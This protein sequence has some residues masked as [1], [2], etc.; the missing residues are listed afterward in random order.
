MFRVV[1]DQL[2][3]SEGW[4]RC[5][6][7]SEVFDATAFLTDESASELLRGEESAGPIEPPPRAPDAAARDPY[8]ATAPASLGTRSAELGTVPAPAWQPSATTAPAEFQRSDPTPVDAADS[9]QEPSSSYFGTESQ[10]LEASP[11][12]AP[13]VFRPS[14]MIPDAGNSVLPPEPPASGFGA[15]Q[16]APSGFGPSQQ[17]QR[18]REREHEEPAERLEDVS[19]VRQARRKAFWRRP[20]VRIALAFVS[21]LLGAALLLQVAY[22]DRNRLAVAEPQLRP[23]LARMC[24]LLQ[25]TLGPPRQ[26]E[27]VAI[28]NSG[29]NRLRSDAYRLSVTLR[30]AAPV[31]VAAPSVELTITDAQDQ[32]IARR[33][34][35]AAELGA[36]GDAL[37]AAG[38]WSTTVGL[39]LNVPPGTRVAG[40][41]LLAFYP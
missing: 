37:P 40:Y 17:P 26:I 9:G 25:C 11:L 41:R 22:E 36:P 13:F 4:V 1:P 32:P 3:I 7:C 34:I 20:M 2:K 6:H 27:A 28:E 14:E 23:A 10:S 35:S 24:E 18:E 16:P 31:P 5:G 12:D 29:F 33:V 30:N 39:I 19:F 15:S 8:L 38:E 21:L